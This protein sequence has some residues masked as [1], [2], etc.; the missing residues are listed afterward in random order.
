MRRSQE[1]PLGC[2]H[3]DEMAVP[4]DT[5]CK[6]NINFFERFILSVILRNEGN[7]I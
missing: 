4:A 3:P 5:C 2:L 1:R 7:N 6:Y